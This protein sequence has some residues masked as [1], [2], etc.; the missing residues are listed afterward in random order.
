M[1]SMLPKLL[2]PVRYWMLIQAHSCA[3]IEFHW[4]RSKSNFGGNTTCVACQMH[5]SQSVRQRARNLFARPRTDR[6]AATES[7]ESGLV[8]ICTSCQQE[9]FY[10]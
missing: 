8:S 6:Q 9:A 1:K 4:A 5:T 10:Q 3:I 2:L 7:S